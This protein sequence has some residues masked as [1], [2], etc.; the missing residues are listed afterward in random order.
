MHQIQ[1]VWLRYPVNLPNHW[2]TGWIHLLTK[3]NK[4]PS[5]P[6]ALR[7]ICLQHPV[8]KILAG[9]QCRQIVLQTYD[10]LR[11]L[12]LYAYLPHRGTRECLLIVAEHCRSVRMMCKDVKAGP[13]PKLLGGLQVSLD[14]EKAFDTVSRTLVL[15]AL[16]MY[17]LDPDLFQLVHSWLT[18]HKY[19]IPFKQLIGQIQ[20]HRGI[21]QWAKDAPLLWTLTMSLVLV[22]LQN[23]YS[24]QWLHEHMVVYA[25]D[26]HLRWLIRSTAPAL[27][28]LT[29]LQHVLMTLQAFGFT[30]N[31]QKS[32]A[33]LRLQGQ[34]APAFLR[35]WVSRPTAGPVL[36]LPER[37]WQLP[38]V[39]K[40]AYLGVIIGYRAWDADTTARRITAAKWCFRNLRSWL[41]SDVHPI[42]A[43]LQLY[44]QCVLATVQY[45]I[46]EMGLIQKGFRQVISMINTHHRSIAHSPV[47]LT[48]ESTAHF[49][50]RIREPPPWTT[51]LTQRRRIQEALSNRRAHLRLEAMDSEMPDV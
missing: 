17:N 35:H 37:R 15:R 23:K 27:E 26:I 18:P 45:G 49:F 12:P 16:K 6:Q 46:H 40:T 21:K 39:S 51:I 22:D 28:A 11:C 19:C 7:P 32:V 34:E 33:M 44:K 29:D 25:D 4:S 38:L 2:T 43:R 13:Q 1:Q 47:C 8:N 42:R 50:E 10:R 31:L 30:V 41:V 9:I 14:M 24:H 36:N 3:P 20:A 48:H 5:K